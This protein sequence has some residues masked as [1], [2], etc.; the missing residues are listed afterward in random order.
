[1]GIGG[2]LLKGLNNYATGGGLLQGDPQ[3]EAVARRAALMGFGSGMLK[4]DGDTGTALQEGMQ[5]GVRS[6]M[7][8]QGMNRDNAVRSVRANGGYLDGGE[9]DVGER[10]D[11][12]IQRAF[13]NNDMEGVRSL[14]EMGKS[15]GRGS[16]ARNPNRSAVYRT[17]YDPKDP[18]KTPSYFKLDGTTATKVE[19]M[20]AQALGAT[21]GRGPGSRVIDVWDSE[22]E[23]RKMF[24]DHNTDM[25]KLD[26]WT[27]PTETQ[28][29]ASTHANMI[30]MA[31]ESLKNATAPGRL[32]WLA[33]KWGVNEA[34]NKQRQEWDTSG[35][36][37]VD[38]YLRATTG[39][40]YNKEEMMNAKAMLIPQPGDT[41]EL[42]EHKERMR[43]ILAQN[44]VRVAEGKRWKKPEG[45]DANL[46]GELSRIQGTKPEYMV[47]P[48]GQP[49][50]MVN[51]IDPASLLPE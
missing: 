32:Q 49:V 12:A 10:Y 45:I 13:E 37:V 16:S 9:A 24:V 17:G 42:L 2:F 5:S 27:N 35:I 21:G 11:N 26:I 30:S 18:N 41:P 22:G 29:R 40:A 46:W 15:L 44:I 34:I 47:N 6:G 39:A 48:A 36:Q 33:Q 3:A 23:H 31:N 28:S 25:E 7:A 38:A 1:M 14:V 51:G 20:N 50:Q 19:G 43:E 8:A 4:L